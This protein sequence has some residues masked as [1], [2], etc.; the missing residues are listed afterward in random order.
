MI[1]SLYSKLV[2]IT[3]VIMIFSGL[4]AFLAINTYYHQVLKNQNDEKNMVI[5]EHMASFIEQHDGL[6]VDEYFQMQANVGYKLFLVDQS[7]KEAFYGEAFREN[8]LSRTAIEDVLNGKPYHGM[9]DLPSETFVTGFF[10]NELKNTVGVPFTHDGEQYALF[11]RPDIKLLFSEVHYLTAGLLIVMGVLSLLAM[12]IVAK[13]LIDPITELTIA[14]EKVGEETFT[15]QLPVNRG[16]EIGQLAKSFEGMIEKLSENEQIRKTFISDVSHDLQSPL[17]NIKGYA[18]LLAGENLQEAHR[19]HYAQVIQD[20]TE[21]LSTLSQ[22][23]LLL[24]S[25]DQLS[26]PLKKKQVRVDTQLKEAIRKVHWQLA[27]KDLGLSMQLEE[28]TVEAD[29]GFLEKVWDNLLSNALKYTTEGMIEV[30]VMNDPDKVVIAIE[31]TGEGIGEADLPRLFDRFYRADTSRTRFVS[32]TGLG[33]SIVQEVIEL[34]GGSIH[35]TSKRG[36][37]TSCMVTIPKL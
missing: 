26:S 29:P 2:L 9:A 15:G 1:R 34:H 14:T 19:L 23:L 22:Q 30:R 21:R 31:D 28:A 10:S 20:E 4:F 5:A 12:L 18:N 32:G 17:L 13:K 36:Q 37:G 33:L 8:N 24:T 35:I 25:L 11:L 16:D 6:S 7:G 3:I 27:E